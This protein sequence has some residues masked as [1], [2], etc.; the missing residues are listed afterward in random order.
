MAIVLVLFA[1][2]IGTVLFHVFSPWWFTPIASNWGMIDSTVDLT[3]WV[4]GF[5]FVAVNLF[6]VYAIY[7]FR[8]KP[9]A[10]AAYEPENKQLEYWL[11]GLTTVGIMVLLAPG[12]LVWGRFVAVPEEAITVE[13]VGQ[14]WGWQYRF[15]GEDGVL[16]ASHPRFFSPDNPFG[17]DPDDPA[18]QDDILVDSSEL[19][20]PLDVPVR[21]LGR[22]KDVIHNFAVPQFRVKMD[23][24]PGMVTYYWLTPTRTGEFDVVCMEHCGIGHYNMRGRVVVAEEAEFDQWLA[25]HPTYAEAQDALVTEAS[26]GQVHYATCITC[27]GPS[28][29]GVEA[30]GG[31]RIN[32]LDRDY[33]ARQIHNYRDGRRGTSSEYPLGQQMAAM[34]RVLPNDEAVASV[35]AYIAA[36]PPLPPEEVADDHPGDP[37]RG[38]TLYRNCG[39]CHGNDGLG[40][41]NMGA[42]RLV[43]M[44]AD[45]M[46]TQLRH[47]RDGLR[48]AHRD[49]RHGQQ[50]A[51]MAAILRTDQAIDDVVAYIATLE[52]Q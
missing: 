6:M 5:V 25:G 40:I 23:M 47:F 45:Y 11:T 2:V 19:Y 21:I 18:G 7:R 36:M 8:H 3:V 10:R 41:W 27:H 46:A 50:M 42:P 37:N 17:L 13:V 29:E 48:G 12:L 16:G 51:A 22:A 52:P 35:A 32:G 43:G 28:G 39:I 9:G 20:L 33:L 4:T 31:P 24:L 49:D 14:Q 44:D 26:E 34:S 15:P 1:L 30:L 38:Q